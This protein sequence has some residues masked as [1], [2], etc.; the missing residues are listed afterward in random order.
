MADIERTVRNLVI[1]VEESPSD[2]KL[3]VTAKFD[4]RIAPGPT[5]ID[6]YTVI[7]PGLIDRRVDR[8]FREIRKVLADDDDVIRELV[9]DKDFTID[10]QN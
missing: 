9:V 3:K 5:G 7:L 2:R 4:V 8:L 10:L 1:R 6:S